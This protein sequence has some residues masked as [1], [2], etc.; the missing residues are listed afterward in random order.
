MKKITFLPSSLVLSVFL[1]LFSVKVIAEIDHVIDRV[2]LTGVYT[3][4]IAYGF[5]H[6][7]GVYS[8]YGGDESVSYTHL[9]LPTKA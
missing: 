6:G 7:I 4:Q 2:Y 9:T 5:P 1:V 3:G 8:Y